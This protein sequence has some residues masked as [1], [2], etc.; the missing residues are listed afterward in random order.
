MV[1]ISMYRD[2]VLLIIAMMFIYA[3]FWVFAVIET[4]TQS[5]L[6]ASIGDNPK[7]EPMPGIFS[8][9][10]SKKPTHHEK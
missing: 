2:H 7:F 5:S 6:Y 1:E 8:Y 4:F 9:P 3:F 10:E